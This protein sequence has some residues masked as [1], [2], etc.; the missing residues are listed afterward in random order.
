MARRRMLRLVC[1]T[2][3]VTA[4]G[5]CS[6][7]AGVSELEDWPCDEPCGD[8]ALADATTDVPGI[9]TAVDTGG[10]API[11]SA[12]IDAP[13][14]VAVDT[15]DAVVEG[16]DTA[17]TAP[18]VCNG[19]PVTMVNVGGYSID[20]TE[21]TNAQ[22]AAFLAA[23]PVPTAQSAW[24]LWNTSFTPG[25]TWPVATAK[26]EH[27]VTN[28][29]WCDAAAYC[30][31]AGKRL[32]GHPI[33]GAVPFAGSAFETAASDAWYNACSSGGANS[34]PYPGVYVSKFCVDA[35]YD[36][37]LGTKPVASLTTCQPT[38]SPYVG[39]FDLAGNVAE[40]EDGCERATGSG[41][42]C[43]VRGGN[44]TDDAAHSSCLAKE[45]VE[46]GI[47]SSGIGFR[48]CSK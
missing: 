3:L 21:V 39:V 34:Y 26:C 18:P 33:S 28:V 24:C 22:Y 5:G 8:S 38:A 27:P 45:D 25:G 36:G 9:D 6:A 7:I 29:D 41:D 4:T 17:D 19:A 16:P 46:R 47:A 30:A 14:E 48:C 12:R 42:K 11:D 2:A 40:W 10:D 32:C 35:N 15:A 1:F 23:G 44:F 20:R 43:R 31:Y 13:S 37:K